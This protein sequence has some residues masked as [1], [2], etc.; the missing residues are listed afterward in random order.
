MIR[1]VKCS[2]SLGTD[3]GSD[4]L[5]EPSRGERVLA[6]DSAVCYSC[7][8]NRDGIVGT[9]TLEKDKGA[10]A[11]LGVLERRITSGMELSPLQYA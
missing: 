10:R 2:T 5:Q 4:A 9:R 1:M 7:E 6:T 3:M 8:S 11:G